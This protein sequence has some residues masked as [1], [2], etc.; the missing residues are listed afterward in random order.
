MIT[1][2]PD[3]IIIT[4]R[5]EVIITGY[6]DWDDEGHNCDEMGCSSVEHVL[7]RVPLCHCQIGFT[8]TEA[9]HDTK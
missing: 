1:Q 4:K 7:I 8:V 9:A 2:I 6:P 5:G 3:R